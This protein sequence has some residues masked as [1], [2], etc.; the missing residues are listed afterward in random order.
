MKHAKAYTN[1]TKTLLM[2]CVADDIDLCNGW[3]WYVWW[4]ILICVIDDIDMCDGW[5][6]YV[7]D[8]WSHVLWMKLMLVDDLIMYGTCKW[9]WYVWWM[10]LLF[11]AHLNDIDMCGGWF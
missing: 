2:I 10:I 8:T 1:S 4:M 5:Y 6:W 11:M 9:Y 3:Y 7:C